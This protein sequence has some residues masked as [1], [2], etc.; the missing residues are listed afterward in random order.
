MRSR[1]AVVEVKTGKL[2]FTRSPTRPERYRP[3]LPDAEGRAKL[4]Q[5]YARGADVPQDVVQQTAKKTE[6]V[7]AS[8]LKE[9]LRRAMQFHLEHE[10]SDQIAMGDIDNALEELLFTGGSL[11]RK[12]LG[13]DTSLE[14]RPEDS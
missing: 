2:R 13:G 12:L 1:I 8:F 5:L 4:I 14:T 3:P 6:K 10:D 9:L 7:S 11:N